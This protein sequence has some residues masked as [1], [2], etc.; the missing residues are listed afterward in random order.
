[1]QRLP[2]IEVT[3]PPSDTQCPPL[4]IEIWASHSFSLRGN[5]RNYQVPDAGA[6]ARQQLTTNSYARPLDEAAGS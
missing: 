1:M 2:I 4:L 6:G 3:T 5:F